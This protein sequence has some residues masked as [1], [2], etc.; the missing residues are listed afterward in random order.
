SLRIAVAQFDLIVASAGCVYPFH[1]SCKNFLFSS[2][3]E[4]QGIFL[5]FHLGPITQHLAQSAD[6][7]PEFGVR[8]NQPNAFRCTF[9]DSGNVLSLFFSA[10]SQLALLQYPAPRR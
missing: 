3:G 6:S 1:F 5:S 4:I 9:K 8:S 7:P 2:I 10:L